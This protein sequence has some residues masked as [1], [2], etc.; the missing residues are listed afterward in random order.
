MTAKKANSRFVK[1]KSHLRGGLVGG[2]RG[3]SVST[4]DSRTTSFRPLG[5]SLFPRRPPALDWLGAACK[6]LKCDPLAEV[7]NLVADVSF[8]QI[9]A[10]PGDL[11]TGARRSGSAREIEISRPVIL[12]V[13]PHNPSKPSLKLAA[14][15]NRRHPWGYGSNS[16]E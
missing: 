11:P 3:R 2:A 9:A 15:R 10:I 5:R 13:L 12:P 1:R 8:A 14:V 6:R 4:R 7:R 16:C